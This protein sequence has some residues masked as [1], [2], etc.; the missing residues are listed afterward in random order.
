MGNALSESAFSFR[1][2]VRH[3]SR[4]SGKSG[5]FSKPEHDPSDEHAGEAAHKSREQGCSGP[6]YRR[7]SQGPA[8]SEAIAYP[9]SND[10]EDQIGIRECGENKAD[11]GVCEVKFLFE[12]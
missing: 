2:P 4:R 9:S 7:D 5:A 3:S 8:R 6:D 1:C 10:L 11:L 12:D